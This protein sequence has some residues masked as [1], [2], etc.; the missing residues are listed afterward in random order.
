M[1]VHRG[2]RRSKSLDVDVL[3]GY[4]SHRGGHLLRVNDVAGDLDA[5]PPSSSACSSA[6]TENAITSSVAT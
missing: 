3:P 2:I 1:P 5:P 6:Y 4:S